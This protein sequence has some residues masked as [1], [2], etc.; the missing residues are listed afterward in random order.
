MCLARAA[1]RSPIWPCSRGGFPC[2]DD[3]ASGGGLLPRRFTLTGLRL[4]PKA[5]GLRFLWHFLSKSPCV[6]PARSQADVVPFKCFHPNEMLSV[7]AAPRPVEFG[8]SSSRTNRPA[9]PRSP[10]TGG[11]LVL[12]VRVSS[13]SD[14]QIDRPETFPNLA[15]S[16]EA[17]SQRLAPHE[18][19]LEGAAGDDDARNHRTRFAG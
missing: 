2:P 17:S 7:S 9:T 19:E 13:R 4:A 5:G 11:S 6:D 12:H 8:L 18:L 1:P 16:F 15:S 3:C 10:K 14:G